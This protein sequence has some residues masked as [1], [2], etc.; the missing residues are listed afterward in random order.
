MDMSDIL[1][2]VIN[3][4]MQAEVGEQFTNNGDAEEALREFMALNPV[5]AIGDRVELTAVGNKTYRIP[6]KDQVAMVCGMIEPALMDGE[7]HADMRIVICFAKD[8]YRFFNVEKRFFQ[9][10]A[11]NKNVFNF[12]KN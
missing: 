5:F 1:Q 4:K 9:K 11:L 6:R 7:H 8:N 10:T 3:K 2:E 12:K